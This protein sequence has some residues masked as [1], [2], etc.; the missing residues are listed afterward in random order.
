MRWVVIEKGNRNSI[1]TMNVDL[2]VLTSPKRNTGPFAIGGTDL[3]TRLIA[4]AVA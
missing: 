2:S 4:G 1:I 3:P